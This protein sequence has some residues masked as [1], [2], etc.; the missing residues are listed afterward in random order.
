[1]AATPSDFD[2]AMLFQDGAHGLAGKHLEFRHRRFR[3]G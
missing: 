3:A 1:M 2:K